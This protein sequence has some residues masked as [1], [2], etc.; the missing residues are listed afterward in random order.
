MTLKGQVTETRAL[1]VAE[2][3]GVDIERLKK[4]ARSSE[5]GDTLTRAQDLAT[6]LNVTITPL[7]IIGHK[8]IAGAPEDLLTQIEQNVAEIR[9]NGCDVC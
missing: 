9:K 5:T 3:L 2:K 6:R 8:G 7:Y 4:D 1:E